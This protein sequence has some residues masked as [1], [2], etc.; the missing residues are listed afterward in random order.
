[1]GRLFPLVLV[2]S[3]ALL[4]AAT[5]APVIHETASFVQST[6][7]AGYDLRDNQMAGARFTVTQPTEVTAVGGQLYATGT[8]FGAIVTLGADDLPMPNPAPPSALSGILAM[9]TFSTG[10]TQHT[11]FR[12]PLSITLAP[13]TYGLVFGGAGTGFSGRMALTGNPV[14]GAAIITNSGALWRDLNINPY[15]RMRFVIEGQA[16]PEPATAFLMPTA[17]IAFFFRRH[18]VPLLVCP[19]E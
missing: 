2:A 19:A 7:S 5:A 18:R 3:F 13:G 15:N 10:S 1:M 12:A 14:P 4:T 17:V 9:T 16:V 6:P 11:D 8:L